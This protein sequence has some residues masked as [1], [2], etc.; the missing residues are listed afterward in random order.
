MLTHKYKDVKKL[1]LTTFCV[2]KTAFCLKIFIEI[3]EADSDK[4][5]L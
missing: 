3:L 4:N 1:T 5:Q 2:F